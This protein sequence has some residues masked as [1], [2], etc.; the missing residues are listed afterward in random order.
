MLAVLGGVFALASIFAPQAIAA[1]SGSP[2][3]LAYYDPSL[4][5]ATGAHGPLFSQYV[6]RSNTEPEAPGDFVE[7]IAAPDGSQVRVLVKAPAPAEPSKTLKVAP[8]AS[9][10]SANDYFD[11]A[12]KEAISGGYAAVIFPKAVHDLWRRRPQAQAIG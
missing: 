3:T 8:I 12:I 7:K 4:V 5:K 11:R 9:G 2:N 6:P 10:E 1:E